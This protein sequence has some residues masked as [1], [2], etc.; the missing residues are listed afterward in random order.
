MSE[1]MEDS[2]PDPRKPMPKPPVEQTTQKAM[3]QNVVQT[4]PPPNAPVEVEEEKPPFELEFDEDKELRA[5]LMP[6]IYSFATHKEQLQYMYG[7]NVK[8]EDIVKQFGPPRYRDGLKPVIKT[9]G[10]NI[11]D[12]HIKDTTGKHVVGTFA[13]IWI[14]PYSQVLPLEI[15]IKDAKQDVKT[16]KR[17]IYEILFGKGQ[18]TIGNLTKLIIKSDIFWIEPGV[19]HNFYNSAA[20]PLII[21]LWYDGHVDLRDRYFPK[22]TKVEEAKESKREIFDVRTQKQRT[23][24]KKDDSTAKSDQR[25]V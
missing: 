12:I 11:S 18:L 13:L 5:K 4:P 21:R 20:S 8:E 22:V 15:K 16:D 17:V 2:I 24:P 25:F 3:Q 1:Y 19:E 9:P 14:N 23:V 7:D 10:F 6:T